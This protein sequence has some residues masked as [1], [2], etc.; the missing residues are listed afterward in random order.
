MFVCARAKREGTLRPNVVTLDGAQHGRV[1]VL[2]RKGHVGANPGRS[3]RL[4]RG[5]IFFR[6]VLGEMEVDE[7][8]IRILGAQSSEKSHDVEITTTN[9]EV[10]VD[11]V[12][13]WNSMFSRPAKLGFD[14]L[15]RKLVDAAL[16]RL[17]PIA[18]RTREGAA[19]VRLE[20]HGV[21]GAI[22]R[23][24]QVVERAIKEW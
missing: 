21:Y 3:Q 16:G 5:Q 1:E 17:S 19:S 4:H 18:E 6:R 12:D 24:H 22:H 13:I 14:S 20:N 2:H 7:L 8:R 9:A 11:D 23:L 15:D 10:G